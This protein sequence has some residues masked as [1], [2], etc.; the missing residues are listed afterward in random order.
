MKTLPP[1]LQG[2]L[3]TGATTLAWCWRVIR[4][5][6]AV[7]GF[8]DHDRDV[9]FGATI[10][11]A[12]SGIVSF[13]PGTIPGPGAGVTAGFEFDVPV[14]FDTDRLEISLDGFRHGSIPSIPVMEIK[15]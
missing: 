1:G 12:A 8:T 7:Y 5:D 13:E 3:D 14:R 15:V 10:F 6:G 9:A 4:R 2:H 11:E